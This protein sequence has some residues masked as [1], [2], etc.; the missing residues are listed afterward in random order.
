M[1][2][3]HCYV[4]QQHVDLHAVSALE[5]I[6]QYMGVDQC[7]A[8]KRYKHWVIQV[9][10]LLDD[11]DF[12]S[13]ITTGSYYLLNPN[14]ESYRLSLKQQ[15]KSSGFVVYADV[16]SV[17]APQSHPLVKTLNDRFDVTI[18]SIEQRVVWEMTIKAQTADLAKDLVCSTLFPDQQ[19][20]GLLANPVYE[21]VE[22][23]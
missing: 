7:K 5:A 18:T 13:K 16:S 12:M 15:K 6:H 20:S 3:I 4:Y 14:K 22:L 8:L 10:T 1:K 2:T 19:S 21:T 17:L 23:L 11:D 9:D